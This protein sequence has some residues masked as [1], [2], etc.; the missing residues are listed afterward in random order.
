MSG[1]EASGASRRGAN[2]LTRL[3]LAGLI[4]LLVAVETPPRGASA[5]FPEREPTNAEIVFGCNPGPVEPFYGDPLEPPA[6]ETERAPLGPTRLRVSPD[7]AGSPIHGSGF[8]LEHTLWSCP[9]FRPS[10]RR[11][12]LEPFRPAIVRV[13]SGQLPLAPEGVPPELLG[14]SDYR[15][16]LADP[17]YAPSWELIRRLNRAGV[18]VLLGVWGAP[19]AFTDDGSRRG[20]LLPQHIGRYVEYY[21]TVVDY[22]VNTQGLSIWAATIMNEPDGG[23]G[24]SISPEDFAQVARQLGPSLARYD[25]GLYGPDT[26]STE[27]ALPYLEEL[28][29]EPDAVAHLRA[30]AAHEYS[31]SSGV[32][33]LVEWV[34]DSGLEVP[35]YITEY[36]SFGFGDLDRG[37]QVS[38]EVGFMLDIVTTLVSH[39]NQGV[40]AALYWDAVDYYQAGHAAITTWGL[41]QGPEEAFFPRK[42]YF[43]FLQVLP[44]LQPGAR[45]VPTVSYGSAQLETLALRTPGDGERDLVVVLVNRG[46][47]TRVDLEVESQDGRL[48]L[49]EYVTDEDRDFEH[50]GH[51][52]LNG[53]QGRVYVP[54]RSIVTLAAAAA[55]DE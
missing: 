27:N 29:N 4:G 30:V 33:S 7:R 9:S 12:L 25:V 15:R 55:P 5:Q 26:A 52:L 24:T 19:G 34:S 53:G 10:L 6:I 28:L 37:Q 42:R 46:A 45:V 17:K 51:I 22:V 48:M 39:Y 40:D 18:R 47:A 35:V 14:P 54:A 43:G 16:E 31:P 32:A 23:D 36:T 3:L 50:L 2:L 8:N 11:R 49:E 13:D 20:S 1:G 21:T 41:L 38:D 44:Y